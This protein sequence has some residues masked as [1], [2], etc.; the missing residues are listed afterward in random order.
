[1]KRRLF[2]YILILVVSVSMLLAGCGDTVTDDGSNPVASVSDDNAVDIVADISES[3]TATD[4]ATEDTAE[5]AG[6]ESVTEDASVSD[7]TM[8]A[9]ASDTAESAEDADTQSDEEAV[10]DEE[11]IQSEDAT[12]QDSSDSD[13]G[14]SGEDAS[15]VEVT[16]SEQAQEETVAEPTETIEDEVNASTPESSQVSSLPA[17]D[18][19]PVVL[20]PTAGGSVIKGNNYVSID[21]TNASQGYI[22]VK[23]LGSVAKVKLQLTGPNGVTYTYTISNAQV[24]IPLSVG[25]GTY[26]VGCYENVSGSSYA[27]VYQEDIAFN[28]SNTFGPF[29]YP[30]YYVNFNASSAV[31]AKA[32]SLASGATSDLDTVKRIYDYVT[33]NISYDY[34][35]AATVNKGYIPNVDATLASGTGICFDYAA[36]M[37]A[38][39]RSQGIPARLEVGYAGD[40]YH[41]WISTYIADVGWINGVVEFKGNTWTLM[42]PT[43]AANSSESALRSFIGNGSNYTVKYMY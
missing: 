27:Q 21:I 20:A 24:V 23:Y 32:Q 17:R 42:D 39:L 12:N 43:F 36:L 6:N 19:T 1:M 25:S 30:N 4:D 11:N 41:A 34:N 35:K 26:R 5:D 8:T 14:D 28:I 13:E 16:E 15:E 3:V 18:N 9:D 40:A 10:S 33:T 37:A 7:N 22:I 29:L 2:G 31:V 38:M